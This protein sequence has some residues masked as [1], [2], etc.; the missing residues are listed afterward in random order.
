MR[1]HS[2]KV[3]AGIHDAIVVPV[4]LEDEPE[5]FSLLKSEIVRAF[6]FSKHAMNKSGGVELTII[7]SKLG[8]D[9]DEIITD[10]IEEDIVD[11]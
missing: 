4:S 3:F 1:R 10:G 5:Q 11:E 2:S 9:L 6:E 7:A 8:I